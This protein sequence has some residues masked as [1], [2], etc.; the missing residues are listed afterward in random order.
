[1]KTIKKALILSLSIHMVGLFGGEIFLKRIRPDRR[2]VIYPIRLIDL[3]ESSPKTVIQPPEE[4]KPPSPPQPEPQLKPQPQIVPK[5]VPAKSQEP[6]KGVPIKKK[7]ATTQKQDI[8]SQQKKQEIPKEESG[9]DKVKKINQ[10][11]ERIKRSLARKAE[12][13]SAFISKDFIERQKQMY[14]SR[15]DQLIKENWSIP[16]TFLTEMGDLEAIVIIRIKPNGELED[17]RLEKRSGFHPFDESTI[18]AIKKASPFPP[19]PIDLKD[20]EFEVRFYSNQMG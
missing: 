11:I 14:A 2:K 7:T 12:E 3:A 18:R 10:A 5:K 19:P 16:K 1:M 4:T 8:K 17:A 9:E 13:R 15:I 6:K 20:D